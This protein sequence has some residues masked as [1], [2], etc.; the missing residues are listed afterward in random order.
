LEPAIGT[1][2]HTGYLDPGTS[3]LHNIAAAGLGADDL[4]V[5]NELVR[6]Y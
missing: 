4:I 3:A 5:E 2:G 1:L 6:G